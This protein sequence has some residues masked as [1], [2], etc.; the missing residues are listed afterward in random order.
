MLLHIVTN[1][2][3][4]SAAFRKTLKPFIL[5]LAGA[6]PGQAAFANNIFQKTF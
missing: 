1:I 4:F 2:I 5:L 6:A 3:I